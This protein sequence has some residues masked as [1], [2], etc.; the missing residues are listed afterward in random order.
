MIFTDRNGKRRLPDILNRANAPPCK[1]PLYIPIENLYISP[2]CGFSSTHHDN[3]LSH[4]DQWRKLE[5]VVN[6]ALKVWGEN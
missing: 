3:D 4:D 1:K 5:L 6:T 2:Q